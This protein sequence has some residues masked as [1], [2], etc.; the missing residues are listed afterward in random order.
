MRFRNLG[1]GSGGNST[2]VEASQGITTTRVLVD[3]GFSERELTRR[4]AL[5]GCTPADVDAIFITHEHGDH[6]GR[7]VAFARRHR[8]PLITSRGTWRAVGCE[9][10]DASLLVLVRSGETIALG[11]IEL[12][13]FTVPHDA[14]EPLQLVLSDGAVRLG[15]VTDL[16]CAPLDVAMALQGCQ[17]LLLECNHDEAMLR[18]GPYPPSLQRRILGTHGHLSNAAAADL[19]SR[20]R[21]AGLGAVVA[22]HLS[23]KN[24][25]PA[26]VRE[27]LAP[28]L[29][30]R[31]E[32]IR[33]AHPTLG[34]DWL[35]VG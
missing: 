25:S 9:E 21:H 32:D 29:G 20:C 13:P 19:L 33:V 24:N 5:A 2:L 14:Q 1:S 12:R 35:A 22:A 17:A 23:E 10:F 3:A 15:I 6:V 34:F 31:A 7:S 28:M 27:A 16:G 18:A 8:I 4:L 30:C 26:L 11:D